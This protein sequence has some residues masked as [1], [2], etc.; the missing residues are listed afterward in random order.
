VAL[1]NTS[2]FALAASTG[3]SATT[4]WASSTAVCSG[5][6]MGEAG[7]DDGYSSSLVDRRFDS[8]GDRTRRGQF[9]SETYLD[10]PTGTCRIEN[11][12]T[13]NGNPGRTQSRSFGASEAIGLVP[14]VSPSVQI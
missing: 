1:L 6:S 12:T 11:E 13:G 10:L 14:C 8:E 4:W 2:R 9:H 5:L 3:A 7:A